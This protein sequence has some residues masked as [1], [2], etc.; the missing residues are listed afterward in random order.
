MTEEG[1]SDPRFLR[2]VEEFDGGLWFEA[3]ET[4]ED[5]WRGL[6]GDDRL[7]VQ[8]LIQAAAA[9]HHARRGNAVGAATLREAAL[10]K[11]SLL[12]AVRWGIDLERFAAAFARHLADPASP[13]GPP[14]RL[15]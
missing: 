8:A 4:W 1:A 7:F 3:H 9:L 2:G 6:K 10:A 15:R 14:P 12:P 5:Q 11:L 13:S